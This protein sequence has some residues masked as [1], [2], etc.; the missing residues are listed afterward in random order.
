MPP[1]KPPS[2]EGADPMSNFIPRLSCLITV[3][4]LGCGSVALAQHD[5]GPVTGGGIIGGSTTRTSTKPAGT[6]KRTTPTASTTRRVPP[7][8][9]TE[10]KTTADGYYQQGETLYNAKKYS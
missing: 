7:R 2:T 3:L 4:F 1:A 10:P 9:T 6:T 8:T 5:S